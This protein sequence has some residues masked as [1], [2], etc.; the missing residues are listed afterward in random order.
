[1]P[2]GF[3]LEDGARVAIHP[4]SDGVESCL[5]DAGEIR[6][7]REEATDEAIGIFIDAAFGGT[8][9]VGDVMDGTRF[10]GEAGGRDS[11]RVGELAAII[12]GNGEENRGE[13]FGTETSFEA[14]EQLDEALGGFFAQTEDELETGG[15]FGKDE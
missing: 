6:A 9:G 3:A 12:G 5:R 1:M 15:A 11:G 4:E 14:V 13:T 2:G 10:V 7:L 8:V